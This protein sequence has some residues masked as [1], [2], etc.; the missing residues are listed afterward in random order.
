MPLPDTITLTTVADNHFAV[1]LAALIKS[2]EINHRS[3]EEIH[4]YIV[5]DGISEANRK[6]LINS[7]S[8]EKLRMSWIKIKDAIPS[9]ITL[10]LDSSSFP[11][12]TYIRL[13]IP[14]FIPKHLNKVIYLDAD[15]IV[16]EDISKLW[17]TDL[18]DKVI[19]GV[20]DRSEV[21]S[22][23]WGGIQNFEELG[24]HPDTKYFNTGLLVI[25][26]EKWRQQNFTE[27]VFR[28]I[29][30][31]RKSASFPDQYGLNVV[32]ANQWRELSPLW[33]C[34]PMRN[35]KNPYLIHFIGR[36]PIFKGY[37]YN[38]RYKEQ[39]F[40]YVDQT[41][42]KNYRQRSEMNRLAKKLYNVVS[43]RIKRMVEQ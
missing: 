28:C 9:H 41:E 1:L 17:H 27:V 11:L 34:I 10:P 25:D 6:K 21:V 22:S 24:L 42:W 23:S 29:T 7:I 19:A 12:N 2:I 33:N 20:V 31:N 18:N 13:C 40:E 26:L 39:F 36:K 15:M 38:E 32:F 35:E 30:Q 5:D 14:Y 4:I 43:K 8:G 3:G 16:L 37:N